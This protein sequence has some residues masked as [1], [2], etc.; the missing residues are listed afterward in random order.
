MDITWTYILICSTDALRAGLTPLLFSCQASGTSTGRWIVRRSS[1]RVS[2]GDSPEGTQKM[3]SWIRAPKGKELKTFT[4]SFQILTLNLPGDGKG[5][6]KNYKKD[7]L[8]SLFKTH[9]IYCNSSF[10]S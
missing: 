7:R 9:A 4:K 2:W 6:A 1:G 5:T 8:A 3:R 10:V